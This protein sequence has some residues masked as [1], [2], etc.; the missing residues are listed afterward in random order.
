L[1]GLFFLQK[2]APAGR[3]ALEGHLEEKFIP[4]TGFPKSL[5]SLSN[6]DIIFIRQNQSGY[7]TIIRRFRMI[8]G[9]IFSRA[10]LISA[11]IFLTCGPGNSPTAPTSP[12][13]H[14]GLGKTVS[15][16]LSNANA[17]MQLGSCYVGRSS[18]SS[19]YAYWTLPVTFT[20]SSPKAFIQMYGVKY[21]NASGT[22]IDSSEF[23]FVEGRSMKLVTSGIFSNTC[24][25]QGDSGCF[26]GIDSLYGSLASLT[27]DSIGFSSSV[28]VQ[29]TSNIVQTGVTASTALTI[30][31]QNTGTLAAALSMSYALLLDNSGTPLLWTFV[32]PSPATVP[33]GGTGTF[34]STYLLYSGT[35]TNAKVFADYEDGATA[36]AKTAFAG[37]NPANLSP[38][39][40]LALLAARDQQEL[41]K[42]QK[43]K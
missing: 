4:E 3:R 15:F 32:T 10:I 33:A 35:Y 20:G 22:V 1:C 40:I 34:A 9:K 41:G 6:P 43:C 31:I 11:G 19:N 29:T 36:T 27:A 8:R 18:T 38:P 24:M 2:S 30:A 5:T 26:V 28:P 42:S 23:T 14:G 39:E 12:T 16:T 13:D 21:R 37:E 17:V 25:M 7:S